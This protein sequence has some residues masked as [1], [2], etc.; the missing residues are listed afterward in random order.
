MVAAVN[1]KV[2]VCKVLLDAGADPN[3]GDEYINS[4][5]TAKEKG[6]HSIE[7]K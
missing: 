6:M 3:L 5:R 7:G 4:N 1:D 2:G